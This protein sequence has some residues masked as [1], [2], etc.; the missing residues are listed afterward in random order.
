M[1]K[2]SDSQELSSLPWLARCV[3]LFPWALS[4]EQMSFYLLSRAFTG[5]WLNFKLLRV[6]I[7]YRMKD[8]LHLLGYFRFPAWLQESIV[9]LFV[10]IFKNWN[11]YNCFIVFVLVSA[12]QW[13]I[14]AVCIHISPPSWISQPFSHPTHL[15]HNRAPSWASWALQQ[16]PTIYFTHVN[17]SLPIHLTF[18]FPPTACPHVCFLSASL[19]LPQK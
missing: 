15:G 12:I 1:K 18:P 9:F 16:V 11:I 19:F 3:A 4:P 5:I 8:Y 6:C 2:N 17:L 14:S 7:F 10:R 13:S